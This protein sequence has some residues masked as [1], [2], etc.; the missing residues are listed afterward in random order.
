MMNYALI[1]FWAFLE[2]G[3]DSAPAP[4]A[5]SPF[6]LLSRARELAEVSLLLGFG[7]CVFFSL[8]RQ[9][10]ETEPFLFFFG[11]LFFYGYGRMLKRRDT[12]IWAAFVFA[13]FLPRGAEAS[14]MTIA[15][16]SLETAFGFSLFRF[17]LQGLRRHQ[18]L[19]PVPAPFAGLCESWVSASLL[20]LILSAFFVR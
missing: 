1:L 9:F 3:Q 12:F 20:A 8:P 17:I 16:A 11:A 19:F 14:L 6:T 2:H 10:P 13:V 15:R 18:V 7:G 5:A 4:R